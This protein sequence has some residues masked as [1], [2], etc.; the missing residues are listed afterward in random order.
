MFF[1]VQIDE[2]RVGAGLGL[3][4][5]VYVTHS[6]FFPRVLKGLKR[7]RHYYTGPSLR[8]FLITCIAKAL[9]IKTNK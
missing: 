1:W 5:F 2:T 7:D 6:D 3:H 8:A 4:G 9:K